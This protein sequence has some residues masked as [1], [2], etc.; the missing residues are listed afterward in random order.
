MSTTELIDITQARMDLATFDSWGIIHHGYLSFNSI[1]GMDWDLN[2][3]P[4][5]TIL[6]MTFI[7]LMELKEDR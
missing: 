7:P 4:G 3:P 6:K 1:N 2:F 5:T